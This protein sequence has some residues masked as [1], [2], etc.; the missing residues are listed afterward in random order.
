M[1]QPLV[2]TSPSPW[3]SNRLNCSK[4]LTAPFARQPLWVAVSLAHCPSWVAFQHHEHLVWLT[5]SHAKELIQGISEKL[6]RRCEGNAFSG[7]WVSPTLFSVNISLS[8]LKEYKTH[9]YTEDSTWFLT[10]VL[11]VNT[12]LCCATWKCFHPSNWHKTN[13]FQVITKTSL[14]PPKWPYC[15]ISHQRKPIRPNAFYFS[16]VGHHCCNIWA[17]IFYF[18]FEFTGKKTNT[19]M[20]GNA[21]LK[22]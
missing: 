17:N 22:F 5:A 11:Q 12:V 13:I 16:C 8:S 4:W 20:T 1:R 10:A 15:F 7:L 3:Q 19:P 18:S 2:P 6:R 21:C 14:M 9:A